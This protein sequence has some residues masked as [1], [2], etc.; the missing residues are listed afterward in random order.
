MPGSLEGNWPK[1]A[2]GGLVLLNIVLLVMLALRDPSSTVAAVPSPRDSTTTAPPSSTTSPTATEQTPTASA[3]QTPTPSAEPTPTASSARPTATESTSDAKGLTRMIAVSSDTLAW[4]AVFGPCP[5]DPEVEVS[6]NGGRTWRGT[7]TRLKSVSRL[8]AYSESSVFAVGGSADCETRYLAT[9][10][11][12]EAWAPNERLLGQTWYRVPKETDRVHAPAGR[13]SSPC[14]DELRDLAGLG[15]QGAAALCADGTVRTTQDRG[16]TWRNLRG[17]S[18]GLALGADEGTYV[19]AMRREGCDGVALAL[20]DPGT[21]QIDRDLVRCTPS[22]RGEVGELAV[23]VRGEVVWLWL[24]NEVKV[25][26]DRG[27]TWDQSA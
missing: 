2:I 16:R 22:E 1:V 24:G 13:V 12:G 23:G 6:R 20:L 27:R 15:D 25:S 19:L 10:G 8:R 18:A 5:T 9:G 17:V 14:D 3:E 4:R 21:E 11:P 7:A 26:T